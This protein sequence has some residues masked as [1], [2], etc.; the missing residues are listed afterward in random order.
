MKRT[1][2]GMTELELR[3][4]LVYLLTDG[5]ADNHYNMDRVADLLDKAVFERDLEEALAF[6]HEDEECEEEVNEGF[7]WFLK[8]V[9][10]L[11]DGSDVGS[12]MVNT[13]NNNFVDR[14]EED[15][16]EESRDESDLDYA[17]VMYA[18]LM[19]KDRVETRE[20]RNIDY[21]EDYHSES[22]VPREYGWIRE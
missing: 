16:D 8:K 19:K 4:Y 11:E 10:T 18:D 21:D 17:D 20:Y 3:D 14:V 1:T 22:Y 15:Y 6:L 12:D 9:G 5:T 7:N 13:L 2:V